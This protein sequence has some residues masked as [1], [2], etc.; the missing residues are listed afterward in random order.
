MVISIV[1]LTALALVM[2]MHRGAI[3][4]ASAQHCSAAQRLQEQ[5]Q[6]AIQTFCFDRFD[7]QRCDYNRG[8]ALRYKEFLDKNCQQPRCPAF[9]YRCHYA[10]H[11]ETSWV[12]K[13]VDG[14]WSYYESCSNA[15]LDGS[16]TNQSPVQSA[17]KSE[18]SQDVECADSDAGLEYYVKGVTNSTSRDSVTATEV[19][20]C[21]DNQSLVEWYCDGQRLTNT[22]YTCPNGCSDA[23]C[24]SAASTTTCT[25]SDGGVNFETKG[26]TEYI[27]ST[28]RKSAEDYCNGYELTEF[29][30]L[31]DRKFGNLKY[32]CPNSCEDG[33]CITTDLSCL[34]TI[35]QT[36][37]L[38][39]PI[40]V[41]FDKGIDVYTA[42]QIVDDEGYD[43]FGVCYHENF[44]PGCFEED[45]YNKIYVN[46]T[47]GHE[48]AVVARFRSHYEVVEA[49]PAV[50]MPEDEAVQRLVT[51]GND[52]FNM[53][54]VQGQVIASLSEEI[55]TFQ[56]AKQFACEYGYPIIGYIYYGPGIGFQ[57]LIKVPYG[58][59]DM[60]VDQLQQDR[61][62]QA[63][64]LNVLAELE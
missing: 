38:Q 46:G 12:E 41:Y 29:F 23:A 32:I 39:L 33:A 5:H 40:T 9:P 36:E 28:D 13:C 51:L 16:C 6:N 14:S 24:L 25:D 8:E 44:D 64:G 19:D 22:Y 58:Q 48:K 59:E 54:F 55:V 37:I 7:S 27:S 10:E 4:A 56:E 17:A 63:A 31:P 35:D 21:E 18:I 1:C 60:I 43:V 3:G 26:S 62:V 57:L 61:R 47:N 11:A 30:C 53:S 45:S 50:N 49:L 34:A 52:T 15:C 20:Y 42:L 2:D